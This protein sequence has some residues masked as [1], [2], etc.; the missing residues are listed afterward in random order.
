MRFLTEESQ[1]LQLKN[2][3]EWARTVAHVGWMRW[4]TYG[5]M[6]RLAATKTP[7]RLCTSDAGICKVPPAYAN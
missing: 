4:F 3:A 1:A 7:K 2:E 6:L 5:V